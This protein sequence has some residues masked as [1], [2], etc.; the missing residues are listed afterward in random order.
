M[1]QYI[2]FLYWLVYFTVET[3]TQMSLITNC[4][5]ALQPLYYKALRINPN[6]TT[7][8]WAVLLMI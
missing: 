3:L 5:I 2:H 4:S 8:N 1:V 7:L 6:K